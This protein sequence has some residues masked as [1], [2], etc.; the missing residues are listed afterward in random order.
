MII[1]YVSSISPVDCLYRNA[2]PSISQLDLENIKTEKSDLS[3]YSIGNG[4]SISTGP[5]ASPTISMHSGPPPPYSS[6]P[7]AAGSSVGLSG[8]ISPPESTTRRSTRDERDSPDI[9]KSLP[10]IHEALADKSMP[11]PAPLPGS[12]HH[13]TLPTPSTSVALTFSDGPKGPLNP[14]SQ[15]PTGPRDVFS[16]PSKPLSTPTESHAVASGFTPVSASDMRQPTQ[17]FGYPGSPRAQQPASFH[18]PPLTTTNASHLNHKEHNQ[19]KSPRAYD[20]PRQ[21]MPFPPFN[22]PPSSLPPATEPFQFTAGSRQEEPRPPFAKAANEA[23]YADTVKRHLEVFD[24]ELGLGEVCRAHV[25]LYVS[26]SNY[27]IRSAKL[28]PAPWISPEF[29]RSGISKE[30]VLAT[31]P[32]LCLVCRSWTTSSV[33]LTGSL[34]I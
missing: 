11:F 16:G 28:R 24:A 29:G 15:P 26:R 21:Q 10:S 30:V 31:L 8:Y 14:F 23:Q 12:A 4:L 27:S 9:R 13:Q 6:A 32:N 33:S 17:P 1:H 22:P 34:K 2:L 18:P 25:E 19:P 3:R 5:L 20:A 7:S